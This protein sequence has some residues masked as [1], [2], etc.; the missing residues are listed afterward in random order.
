LLDSTYNLLH[1]LFKADAYFAQHNNN[2][3]K[4]IGVHQQGRVL[5]ATKDEVYNIIKTLG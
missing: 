5:T 3:N 4:L 1:N 2:S